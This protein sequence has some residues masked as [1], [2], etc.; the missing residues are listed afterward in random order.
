MDGYFKYAFGTYLCT[1][2]Q[3]KYIL[4]SLIKYFIQFT[5][6]EPSATNDD[7]YRYA[8]KKTLDA[9]WVMKMHLIDAKDAHEVLQVKEGQEIENVTKLLDDIHDYL[10]YIGD[11]VSRKLIN[12][13]I[14]PCM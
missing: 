7:R 12:R 5:D 10:D 14:L 4:T 2:D 6:E 3:F 11:A 9:I 1:F 8:L 13:N